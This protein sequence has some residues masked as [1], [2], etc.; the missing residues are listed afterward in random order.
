MENEAGSGPVI[1]VAHIARGIPSLVGSSGKG[2]QEK[3]AGRKAVI[4]ACRGLYTQSLKACG[5]YTA[6]SALETLFTRRQKAIGDYMY[7][8]NASVQS[9]VSHEVC[10][11]LLD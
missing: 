1:H 11:N 9:N 7:L 3:A 8:P 2:T 10:M 5:G 4:T 6:F